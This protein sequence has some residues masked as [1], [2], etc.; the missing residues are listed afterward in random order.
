MASVALSEMW[1]FQ[2]L[3]KLQR[4]QPALVERAMRRL[5]DE[6]EGLRWSLVVSAYLDEEISL[7]RAAALLKLHPLELRE[8]FIEKGVPLYLGPIDD[9]D[10]Q[11]ELDALRAWKRDGGQ[12]T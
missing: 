11:A 6:D 4:S 9:A 5:L 7:A 2:Q 3:V 1:S 8:R 12:N 10:A